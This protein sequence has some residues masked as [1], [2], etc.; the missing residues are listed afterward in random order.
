MV[1]HWIELIAIQF[2]KNSHTHVH[3]MTK[4]FLIMAILSYEVDAILNTQDYSNCSKVSL[5]QQE[6]SDTTDSVLQ[7][8]KM[9][10]T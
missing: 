3:E 1:L 9:K 6:Y 8:S 10:L 7:E 5:G 4:K 2:H